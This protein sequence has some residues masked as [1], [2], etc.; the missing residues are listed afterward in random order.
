MLASYAS[1]KSIQSV[2]IVIGPKDAGLSNWDVH[3]DIVEV[4]SLLSKSSYS[5]SSSSSS[6]STEFPESLE[7][8]DTNQTDEN[9]HLISFYNQ[10][11]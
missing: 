6:S 7:S 9:F 5:S 8:N 10:H 11:L 1:S 3:I 2:L 4:L